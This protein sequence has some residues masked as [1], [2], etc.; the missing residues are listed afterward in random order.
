MI[1]SEPLLRSLFYYPLL[2]TP[3]GGFL[4]LDFPA[5]A[6]WVYGLYTALLGVAL[7]ARRKQ[8]STQ[9]AG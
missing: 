8:A 1:F 9:A 3:L 7:V 4:S 6:Y 5:W 2:I